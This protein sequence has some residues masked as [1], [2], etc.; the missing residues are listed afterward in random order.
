LGE[1]GVSATHAGGTG[2]SA[3]GRGTDADARAGGRDDGTADADVTAFCR[4][5]YPRLVRALSLH[6]GDRRVA[7]ELA[8]ETLA[9][10]WSRWATVRLAD[11][12]EAWAFR[13][14]FNLSNS[15]LRRVG[16]ERRAYQRADRRHAPSEPPCSADVLA[17]RAAVAALPKR[18]RA[19]MVLR[20]FLDLSVDDSAA[21]L[22]CAPGTVKSLTSRAVGNLRRELAPE[23][24][25]S[26]GGD[27]EP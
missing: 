11:S 17:V 3:A 20:F 26:I 21:I 24:V 18:Q 19:V 14:G 10:V 8:Q 25:A 12:P 7:E 16:A 4:R 23:L 6:C 9:R 1:E 15:S 22:G 27:G 13:V 2:Q 5:V